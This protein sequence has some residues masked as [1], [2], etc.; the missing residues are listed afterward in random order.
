[1]EPANHLRGGG[2]EV[3]LLVEVVELLV[4]SV[5]STHEVKVALPVLTGVETGERTD[6][7]VQVVL[8]DPAHTSD[9]EPDGS[10][11][12]LLNLLRHEILEVKV[13]TAKILV[14]RS[15]L[16][17]EGASGR[18]VLNPHP[19]HNLVGAGAMLAKPVGFAIGHEHEVHDVHVRRF[20]E[21]GKVVMHDHQSLNGGGAVHVEHMGQGVGERVGCVPKV[22]GVDKRISVAGHGLCP[23]HL[24]HAVVLLVG[25]GVGEHLT[26]MDR[27][28]IKGVR[29]L[30]RGEQRSQLLKL[31]L[32]PVGGIG[33]EES[34]IGVEI[35]L[36]RH[37]DLAAE[38][39]QEK[40][41]T[42]DAIQSLRH[43]A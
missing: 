16:D 34:R 24:G 17:G 42:N 39:S 40:H 43:A 11:A 28:K 2:D 1:M 18:E 3:L 36:V 20:P 30:D 19:R 25:H 35:H 31:L 12:Q 5:A 32:L 38:P 33:M 26:Q 29:C 15:R 6:E 8:T 22:G 9:A 7:A 27:S 37:L 14:V 21:L 23:K 10:H 4:R 13:Q 41:L